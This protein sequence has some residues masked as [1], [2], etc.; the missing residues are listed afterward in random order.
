MGKPVTCGNTLTLSEA[1]K[2]IQLARRVQSS[3]YAFLLLD[4][5]AK[6]IYEGIDDKQFSGAYEIKR[7]DESYFITTSVE[8]FADMLWF[9]LGWSVDVNCLKNNVALM[10]L[11]R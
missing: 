5:K 11:F 10:R 8:S 9:E 3:G 2:L 6:R 4:E 1:C 7:L